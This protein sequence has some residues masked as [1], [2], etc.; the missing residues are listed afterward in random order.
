[1]EQIDLTIPRRSSTLR[2]LVEDSLRTAILSGRFGGGQRLIERELCATFGVGRTSIREA[3]RQLEAE[4]LVTTVPHRGP[5][6]STISYEDAEY[7]YAVRAL[8]ESFAG[9]QFAERG[10]RENMAKLTEAL[11]LCESAAKDPD[12][13]KILS[14]KVA[15]YAVIRDGC[16]NPVVGQI[17]NSLHNRVNLLRS[18]SMSQEGRVELS[19]GEI[20]EIHDAIL[21]RDGAR[22]AAACRYHVEMAAR[23]ALTM[24]RRDGASVR[25]STDRT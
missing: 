5:V 11:I 25:R 7:I 2:A 17:L 4:G 16:G 19:I 10:S 3:F 15:F 21:A 18:R 1:M 8:I 20:R 22:A 9:Q 12:Q 13:S 24:L 6:V 14:A 23:A